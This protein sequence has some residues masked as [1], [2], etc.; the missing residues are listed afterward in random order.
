MEKGGGGDE[1]M[2]GRSEME[3]MVETMLKINGGVARCWSKGKH[4]D[5]QRGERWKVALPIAK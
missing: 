3:L 1:Q 5:V 2:G 4:E